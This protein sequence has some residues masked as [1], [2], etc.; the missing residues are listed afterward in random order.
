MTCTAN[1]Y[2]G[3]QI[4]TNIGSSTSSTTTTTISENSTTTSS[5]IIESAK[6]CKAC[7]YGKIYNS[8][9][10]CACDTANGFVV[11]ADECVL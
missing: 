7:P 6:F 8:N 3:A 5:T 11:A 10:K 1:T 2:P 9:G 4:I